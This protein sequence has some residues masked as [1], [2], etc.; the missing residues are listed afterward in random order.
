MVLNLRPS[1]ERLNPNPPAPGRKWAF[2]VDQWAPIAS[3]NSVF[4]AGSSNN[5]GSAVDRF[6]IRQ[7]EPDEVVRFDMVVA[8]RDSD[9]F[10]YRIGFYFTLVGR[11]VQVSDPTPA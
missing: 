10:L 7:E 6:A 9:G 5:A 1:I 3:L 11:L 4:N 8:V 2:D